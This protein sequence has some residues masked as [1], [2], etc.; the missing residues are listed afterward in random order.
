MADE[1]SKGALTEAVKWFTGTGLGALA[2]VFLKG[3]LTGTTGQESEVR[4]AL[5][6]ETERLNKENERLRDRARYALEWQD[7]AKRARWE[8][9][10]LGYDP[11]KWPDDPKEDP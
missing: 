10:K 9:E 4:K 7:L 11:A 1:A 2:G 5:Q 6:E 3:L 8:A